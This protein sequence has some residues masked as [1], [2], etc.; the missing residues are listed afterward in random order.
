MRKNFF[1][2]IKKIYHASSQYRKRYLVCPYPPVRLWIEPTNLC[3]LNCTICPSKEAAKVVPCGYMDFEL[4]KE[5]IEQISK[6]CVDINL[7]NRGESLLHP[8]ICQMIRYAR[9]KGL[10]TRLETNAT[11]LDKGK[12]EE[13]LNSGLDFI[14]F[15]FDGYT[16]Q[17]YEDIRRGADFDKILSNILEFLRMKKKRRQNRPYTLLQVIET[18]YLLKNSTIQDRRDFKSRFVNLPLNGFRII[19]PHRF[20]GKIEE[21][22]VGARYAYV[23][24]KPSIF[25]VSYLPCP[26]LWCSMA[27]LWDGTIL[28]CCVN[29]FIEY[30]LGSVKETPIID[31][32]NSKAMVDL[33]KKIANREFKAVP[34]C[35]ECDFLWQHTLFG[36]STKNIKDLFTFIKESIV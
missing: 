12:S 4:Y 34:M 9:E 13:I 32:W 33:R 7:F 16:R 21:S 28:P 26:Y 29:F 35:R 25:K 10:S 27:I 15:S 17:V 8:E 36:F 6:F 24:D 22:A 18:E 5:I 31:T 11:L 14:S 30:P 3:N 19:S 2:S 20:G 1:A 23:S